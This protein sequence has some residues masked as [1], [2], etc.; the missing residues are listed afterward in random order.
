MQHA[1]D[2][3]VL[4]NPEFLRVADLLYSGPELSSRAV[5]SRASPEH[6]FL[7]MHKIGHKQ[8]AG[9]ALWL[10]M[11]LSHALPFSNHMSSANFDSPSARRG[12][13]AFNCCN[14]DNFF[15]GSPGARSEYVKSTTN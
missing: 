15:S 13:A 4:T 8:L 7:R 6:A 9:R 12:P 10:V 2:N 3:K 11:P 1:L 5:V 14:G